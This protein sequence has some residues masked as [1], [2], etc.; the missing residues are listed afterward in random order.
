ML[1]RVPFFGKFKGGIIKYTLI[2][3]NLR[4]HQNQTITK[5][6]LSSSLQIVAFFEITRG[7]GGLVSKCQVV[8][9]L[10]RVVDAD[11]EGDEDDG[12]K[13]DV[14]NCRECCLK[15]RNIQTLV[16]KIKAF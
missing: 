14:V 2:C 1:L 4:S 12:A 16:F 7:G 6:N 5:S 9:L 3:E 11:G 10:E 8:S 15:H 13:D